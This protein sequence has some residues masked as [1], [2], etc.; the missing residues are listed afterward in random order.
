MFVSYYD[1][2][3]TFPGTAYYDKDS[4]IYKAYHRNFMHCFNQRACDFSL[5]DYKEK[6]ITEMLRSLSCP[7]SEEVL[8]NIKEE[9]FN[10]YKEIST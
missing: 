7:Y 5:K 4:K 10:K 9:M 1:G 2:V 6:S 3:K 8:L